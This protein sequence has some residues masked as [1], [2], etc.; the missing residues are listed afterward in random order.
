MDLVIIPAGVPI[1]PGMT[2]DD[3]FKINAGIQSVNST[4][5]IAAEVFKK[6]GTYDPKCLLGVTMLDVVRANTFAFW[7]LIHEK[8]VTRWLEEVCDVSEVAGRN[9]MSTTSTT[10]NLMGLQI[11]VS[12]MVDADALLEK[13]L[14]TLDEALQ[15]ANIV[16]LMSL[17]ALSILTS[18]SGQ[19]SSYLKTLHAFLF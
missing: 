4:V 19:H 16:V 8:L 2:P 18:I 9:V 6:A 15:I 7:D 5:Q 17:N 12:M 14:V 3:L 10:T 11:S 1:K 13:D